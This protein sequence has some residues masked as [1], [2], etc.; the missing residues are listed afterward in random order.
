VRALG[1]CGGWGG[2]ADCGLKTVG[3]T[4]NVVVCVDSDLGVF[5]QAVR[6]T[7][8]NRI[9]QRCFMEGGLKI[10]SDLFERYNAGQ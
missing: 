8:N 3:F 9:E 10:V 2:V 1:V 5:W 6:S 4:A 7:A